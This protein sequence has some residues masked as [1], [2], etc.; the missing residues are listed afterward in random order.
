[1][2]STKS[3]LLHLLKDIRKRRYSLEYA[4]FHASNLI[5]QEGIID[6]NVDLSD[7]VTTLVLDTFIKADAF[8]LDNWKE[9]IDDLILEFEG[10]GK[11]EEIKVLFLLHKKNIMELYGRYTIGKISNNQLNL[12]LRK[13]C[14]SSIDIGKMISYAST[15]RA[16]RS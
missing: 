3:G 12:A 1:M 10:T 9:V 7:S 11:A 16:L 14:Q 15:E 6:Y 2:K 4:S 13:Y 8:P 5:M